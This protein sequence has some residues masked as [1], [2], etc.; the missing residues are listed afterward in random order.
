MANNGRK[1]RPGE[2]QFVAALAVGKSIT[3]ASQEA[4]ISQRTAYR[5]LAESEI[6]QNIE[7]ARSEM[8]KQALAELSGVAS[9]AVKTLKDLLTSESDNT[10]LGAARAILANLIS[11][12]EH[13][14]LEERIAKLEAQFA[15]KG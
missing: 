12:K 1:N 4:G 6:K 3:E 15:Q 11:L 9:D 8:T 7:I 5:W 10:K 2:H 13:H 14:E